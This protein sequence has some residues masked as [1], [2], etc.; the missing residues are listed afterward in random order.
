MPRV[1]KCPSHTPGGYKTLAHPG[2]ARAPQT[3]RV[4]TCPLHTPGSQL[5][6]LLGRPET[7][8]PVTTPA[9]MSHGSAT[10]FTPSAELLEQLEEFYVH[11]SE[12]IEE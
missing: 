6:H 5:C 3:P 8:S 1:Y 4:G 7:R 12:E 11:L 2:R 9:P 10:H